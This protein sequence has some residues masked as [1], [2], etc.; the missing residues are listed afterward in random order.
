MIKTLLAVVLSSFLFSAC[1]S[2]DSENRETLQYQ[3]VLSRGSETIAMGQFFFQEPRAGS[4][5]SGSYHLETPSGSPVSPLQSTT[6]DLTA[7]LSGDGTIEISIDEPTAPQT[8][9][10]FEAD[11]D[12]VGFDGTWFDIPLGGPSVQGTFTAVLGVD[13]L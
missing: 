2:G 7:T 10:G 12:H 4:A 8:G 3:V 1:D 13:E 5:S 11:Y 9:L 6:G